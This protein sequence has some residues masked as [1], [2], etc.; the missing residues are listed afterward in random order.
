MFLRVILVCGVNLALL[1]SCGVAAPAQTAPEPAAYTVTVVNAMFGSPQ[2]M[3]VYRLGSKALVDLIGT[4]K[5]ADPKAQHTRSLYDLEK[6]R[7]LSWFWPDSSAGCGS[8]TFSGD[9]GDP[10]TGADEIT[11]QGAALQA[12]VVQDPQLG[13]EALGLLDPVE[14][15]ALGHHGQRRW[16]AALAVGRP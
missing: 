5:A 10:F 9:W 12:G 16:P 3:K 4:D 11:G 7:N 2:T 13:R 15:E 1:A 8:G 14:D 6:H